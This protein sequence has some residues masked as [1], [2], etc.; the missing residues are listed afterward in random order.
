MKA[1]VKTKK[2]WL[3]SSTHPRNP[4]REQIDR[5][6]G[7]VVFRVPFSPTHSKRWIFF[8]FV[9][10]R[11]WAVIVRGSRSLSSNKQADVTERANDVHVP[12]FLAPRSEVSGRFAGFFLG[13]K[14]AW[15]ET[16]YDPFARPPLDVR[17]ASP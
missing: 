9:S 14:A 6:L 15:Y 4:V 12:Q 11:R 10:V 3:L 2:G 5:S 8:I 16:W 1:T 17:P 7:T 13:F